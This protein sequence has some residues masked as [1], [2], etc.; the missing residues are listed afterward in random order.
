[1]TG[2][3]R[4][5]L[6]AMI[7]LPLIT[8][9]AYILWIWPRPRGTSPLAEFAPYVASLVTGLPFAWLLT[10]SGGRIWILVAFLSGGFVLLWILAL[11]LLCGV[12]GV[13]L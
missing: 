9:T 11:A 8:L 1:M 10:R 5:Y 12:R 13:C 4:W 7:G 2:K 6:A 3:R